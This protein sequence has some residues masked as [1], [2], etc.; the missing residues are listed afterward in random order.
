MIYLI[1]S[2]ITLVIS[3]K[4]FEKNAGTMSL[5]E[6]NLISFNY[7]FQLIFQTFIGVNIVIL[8]LDNHYMLNKITD[9]GIKQSAYWSVI[10]ILLLMPLSMLVISKWS[11][12]DAAAEWKAFTSKQ[13]EDLKGVSKRS[14]FLTLSL[15]TVVSWS[16]ILYT[17]IVIGTV[18]L[19]EMMFTTPEHGSRLRII[20]SRE[21]E[22]NVYIRNILGLALTPILTYIA[23][24]YAFKTKELKWRVLF[25]LLAV[26]SL[27]ML[28][29]DGSKAKTAFFILSFVFLHVILKGSISI[30]KMALF[31]APVAILLMAFYIF[32][33]EYKASF[34][35]I[36]SGPLG[37]ML[38]GQVS[39]LYF[40]LSYFPEKYGF[41]GLHGFSSIISDFL[42]LD[43]VRSARI[44][45]ETVNPTGVSKGTAG[46]MNTI[47]IGEAYAAIGWIGIVLAIILVGVVIQAIYIFFVRAPKTPLHIAMLTYLTYS[48]PLTGGFYDFIYNPTIVSVVI[49]LLAIYGTM[50]LC[51]Y[52]LKKTKVMTDE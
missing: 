17:F 9:V 34:L 28:S 39:G 50:K 26:G 30:R 33:F 44:V 22:G 7:Y 43:G 13:I 24:A 10:L 35:D 46:V 51:D 47:F 2:V 38:L 20:A 40:H 19:I 29:Y 21:F 23:Y 18:P 4:L 3:Y 45:M 6:L 52:I 37:R 15:F 12:F 42:G 11:K 41:L 1:V 8:G 48:L 36:N 27:L 32:I 5:T 25:A 16:A 31:I 49:I 14:E